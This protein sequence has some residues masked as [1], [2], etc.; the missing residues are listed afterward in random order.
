MQLQTFLYVFLRLIK[1]SKYLL[2]HMESTQ[3][4]LNLVIQ[5][6]APFKIW[7]YRY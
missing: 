7:N 3:F 2:N 1:A 6:L 4:F 5:N